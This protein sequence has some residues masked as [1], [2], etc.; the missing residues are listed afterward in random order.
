[1]NPERSPSGYRKFFETDVER[2]RWVLRQQRE[3]FLPLKVIRDRLA[4]GDLG[5]G[6]AAPSESTGSESAASES[7]GSESAESHGNGK[8]SEPAHAAAGA[9]GAGVPA[10]P[11]WVAPPAGA[12]PP[13]RRNRRSSRQADDEAMARILADASRRSARAPRRRRRDVAPCHPRPRGARIRRPTSSPTLTRRRLPARPSPDRRRLRRPRRC[14]L[15]R[16]ESSAAGDTRSS[17]RAA[18]PVAT[19]SDRSGALDVDGARATPR[20]NG[21]GCHL[22]LRLR[23][24]PCHPAPVR[25]RRATKTT[26]L[27]STTTSLRARRRTRW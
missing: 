24:I 6:E 19:A 20:P 18:A 1:M 2:L 16:P 4:D 23:P 15:P 27:P 10:G 25:P 12:L 26:R 11:R 17:G 8:V 9:R 3:H 14:P 13:S 7:A 21:C 22:A 5:E